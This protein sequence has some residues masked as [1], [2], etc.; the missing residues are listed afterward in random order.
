VDVDFGFDVLLQLRLPAGHTA[1]ARF[2]LIEGSRSPHPNYVAVHGSAGTLLLSAAPGA[3]WP[4]GT[5]QRFDAADGRWE[6]VPIPLSVV[7]ALPTVED[8]VQ[9]QWHQFFAEVAA[10]VRGEGY[11]GYP[12]FREGW[13]AVEVMDIA[14]DGQ[15]W[16]TLPP[17]RSDHGRTT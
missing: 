11:R 16:A 1:T 8:A 10:D 13:M 5:L 6:E 15:S 2:T 17:S 14:R 9:Q 7:A 3:L 4:D 12:T